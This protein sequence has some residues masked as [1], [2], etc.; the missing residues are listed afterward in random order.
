MGYNRIEAYVDHRNAASAHILSKNG[1]QFKGT[2]REC[3]FE[4]GSY[5]D[6][7]VYSI[8]RKYYCNTVK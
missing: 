4:Y 1:F 3:E 7:D 8:L 6:L 5:V 2:L